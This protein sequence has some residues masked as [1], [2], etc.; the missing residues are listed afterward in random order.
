M[1]S[2]SEE[3]NAQ[4]KSKTEKFE[5]IP[6][7]EQQLSYAASELTKQPEYSDG[8]MQGFYTYVYKHFKV[9]KVNKDMTAR[10]YL[11]FVI[12][13][14][15]SMS[16]IKILRDPGYGMGDEA[17]RVLKSMDQKWIPGELNGEKVS[18]NY[19]LPITINITSK[20]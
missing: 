3:A 10:I 8:G 20:K 17:V 18:A 16:N 13:K 19:N 4:E 9:P 6:L 14:D 1:L 2:L 11:S 15:G 5:G 12:E 7:V